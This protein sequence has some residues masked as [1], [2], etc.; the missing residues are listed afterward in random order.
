MSHNPHFDYKI[1][2]KCNDDLSWFF[3]RERSKG[4]RRRWLDYFRSEQF[5]HDGS[6]I[7]KIKGYFN[8][9]K[10]ETTLLQLFTH[11]DQ[12]HKL[13][14]QEHQ[15][16]R[17]VNW[18]NKTHPDVMYA[19][20]KKCTVNHGGANNPTS[21]HEAIG[22]RVTSEEYDRIRYE[23]FATESWSALENIKPVY[24]EFRD[25]YFKACDEPIIASIYNSITMEFARCNPLDEILEP[26]CFA[27]V[28]TIDFMNFVSLAKANNLKFYI[29]NIG[30]F[31][32]PSFD[33]AHII[34]GQHQ[35]D[36]FDAI[37][38]RMADDKISDSHV[39]G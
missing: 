12:I 37:M 9:N 1:I 24:R 22:Q 2:K 21:T 18:L 6:P 30:D 11:S 14:L 39:L 36:K 19:I 32:I 5:P 29:D 8:R 20:S 16:K 35:Y 33:A 28:P 10:Q 23:R 34:I 31:S 13:E 4:F 3:K 15:Y 38:Q 27:D 25:F 26:Y 17:L 7:E